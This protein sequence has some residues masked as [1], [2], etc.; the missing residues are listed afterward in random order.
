M[1]S[2]TE[3]NVKKNIETQAAFD[4]W[5]GIKAKSR[6]REDCSMVKGV[7]YDPNCERC[8]KLSAAKAKRLA[9][10]VFSSK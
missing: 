10:M 3:S 7:I 9:A 8:Q 4:A 2:R 1:S 5:F 6:H